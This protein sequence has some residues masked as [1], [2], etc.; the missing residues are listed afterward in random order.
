VSLP[1]PTRWRSR[2][3]H[4][5]ADQLLLVEAERDR[6]AARNAHL[7]TTLGHADELIT[8]V[9]QNAAASRVEADEL[10]A[11]RDTLA[12]AQELLLVDYDELAAR[13]TALRQELLNLRAISSPAPADHGP[14]IPLHDPERTVPT[15]AYALW[16]APG[17]PAGWAN[18]RVA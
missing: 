15:P 1:L 14:A 3:R 7:Q 17:C 16:D 13:N 2:G 4:R 6:L 8:L 10:R 5:A 18:G 11:E 12:E 9:C